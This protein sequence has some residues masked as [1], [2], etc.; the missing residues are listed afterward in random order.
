MKTYDDYQHLDLSLWQGHNDEWLENR[1]NEWKHVHRILKT[2][3]ELSS[4][5]YPVHKHFFM[6][7]EIPEQ[8][9]DEKA[10]LW[11]EEIEVFPKASYDYFKV[12]YTPGKNI[13]AVKNT[14]L[15]LKKTQGRSLE[16][17]SKQ[18][19]GGSVISMQAWQ[20]YGLMG[21]K[22]DLILDLLLPS[23][24]Q[25][26]AIEMADG[27]KFEKKMMQ[28]QSAL[29]RLV[30]A[31][32]SIFY[33]GNYAFFT[34]LKLRDYAFYGVENGIVNLDKIRSS[35]VDLFTVILS[36]KTDQYF[37]QDNEEALTVRLQL[38][39]ELEAGEWPK[40]LQDVYTTV[41]AEG[42]YE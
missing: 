13:E 40:A 10:I 24:K 26:R 12:W 38:F 7:G 11:D 37:L 2:L 9:L 23:D 6:T 29:L 28:P 30:S 41:K 16:N 33:K 21:W 17:F 35:L 3:E 4:R 32:K 22:E 1:K 34:A 14:I 15:T 25:F 39:N 8:Y 5:A 31:Y 18:T 36:Y 42:G 27:S 19:L 20:D